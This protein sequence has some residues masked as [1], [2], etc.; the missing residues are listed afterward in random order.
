MDD[1]SEDEQNKKEEKDEFEAF[2]ADSS[3]SDLLLR[4][5]YFRLLPAIEK[6]MFY[7]NDQMCTY[8]RIIDEAINQSDD[9][10]H[11]TH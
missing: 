10:Y 1:I 5:W 3:G 4:Q 11:M 7:Y 9:L 6:H 2:F 8:E